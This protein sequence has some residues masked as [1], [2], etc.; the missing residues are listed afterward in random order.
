M[1]KQIRY[2]RSRKVKDTKFY[3]LISRMKYI[4]RWS[5]MRNSVTENI[6]EHSHMVAVIAHALGVIGNRTYGKNYNPEHLATIAMFHD[7]TEILTGDMPTPIKYQN[8]DIIRA[9]H[10][11]EAYAADKLLRMIPEAL[12]E[13]YEPLLN[14][15]SHAKEE[16]RLVKAADKLS[17]L[18][19]CVEERKAGNSEFISAE[20]STRESIKEMGLEEADYFMEHFMPAFELDLDELGV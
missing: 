14:P 17:A 9:Y 6:Q 10:Q 8:P 1:E 2:R 15:D 12:R 16:Y 5:L 3:A 20:R 4:A 18:I 13:D 11:V 7:A 19:K